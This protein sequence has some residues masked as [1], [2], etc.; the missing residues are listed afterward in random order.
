MKPQNT[1]ILKLIPTKKWW[2]ALQWVQATIELSAC[3]YF[4]A[5]LWLHGGSNLSSEGNVIG[6]SVAYQI[7]WGAINAAWYGITTPGVNMYDHKYSVTSINVEF[8]PTKYFLLLFLL[9]F[10]MSWKMMNFR[11]NDKNEKLGIMSHLQICCNLTA[12]ISQTT[13]S[14]NMSPCCQQTEMGR[15]SPFLPFVAFITFLIVLILE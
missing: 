15:H 5:L 14:Y 3:C 12:S 4:S 9:L 7:T 13:S 2:S 8:S 1:V 6:S 11:I 10:E